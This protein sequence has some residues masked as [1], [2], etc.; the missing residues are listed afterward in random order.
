MVSYSGRE[1]R[2][3]ISFCLGNE[4]N[5]QPPKRVAD[6]EKMDGNDSFVTAASTAENPVVTDVN[7][8]R[9]EK[10]GPESGNTAEVVVI[11]PGNVETEA[12]TE[13]LHV[14][15]EPQRSVQEVPGVFL[16]LPTTF[17]T[18]PTTSEIPHVESSS[19]DESCGAYI[20][21]KWE[22][23]GCVSETGTSSQGDGKIVKASERVA[24]ELAPTQGL[25]SQDELDTDSVS[26]VA[27]LDPPK[28][29]LKSSLKSRYGP[30]EAKI[31]K[32]CIKMGDERKELSI[33][34]YETERPSHSDDDK[35][36]VDVF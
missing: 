5:G 25:L 27:F 35:R 8:G 22:Q 21:R 26:E 32:L 12:A 23:L 24:M 14:E 10:E 2:L 7:V 6:E 15:N 4:S 31:Q 9:Q 20:A 29:P 33:P 30:P 3:F 18:L 28:L 13:S 34:T 17:N 36:S 11:T 16:I 19:T 1:P